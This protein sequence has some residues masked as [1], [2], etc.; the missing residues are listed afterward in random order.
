MS[1]EHQHDIIV[2]TNDQQRFNVPVN[3][4]KQS[5]VF[6][7]MFTNNFAEFAESREFHVDRIDG[8]VFEKVLEW[9]VEHK[10]QSDPQIEVDPHTRERKWFSYTEFEK[11]FLDQP[12][13]ELEQIIMAAS[14]LDISSLYLYS[15]QAVAAKLKGR[16]PEEIRALLGLPDDLTEE[17]KHNIRQKNVWTGE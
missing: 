6:D 3:V 13:E 5:K 12:V 4:M 11:K 17:E 2:V 1:R 10:G 8:K 9:C 15:C 14:Y 16:T 7:T